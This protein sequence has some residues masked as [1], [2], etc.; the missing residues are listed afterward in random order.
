MFMIAFG[1]P[2]G[3]Y[4]TD[5]VVLKSGVYDDMQLEGFTLYTITEDVEIKANPG[6]NALVIGNTP[7]AIN[8][9]KGLTLTIRGGNA[10]QTTGAGAAIL[11]PNNECGNLYITG[12]GK[13][14][15]YGGNGANGGDGGNGGDGMLDTTW[16]GHFQG[17]RGGT[18]GYGGGGAAAAI[19]G[20]G[21]NGH[22]E[23]TGPIGD[24]KQCEFNTDGYG[25]NGYNSQPG[26]NGSD[27]GKVYVI[28]TVTVEAYGGSAGSYGGWAGQK[29][30]NGKNDAGSGW[31]HDYTASGGA[32]GGGGGS[33]YPADAIGGGAPGAQCG[34]TGASGSVYTTRTSTGYRYMI[35][36]PGEGGKGYK[37]GG[38]NSEKLN[39]QEIGNAG[40]KRS[41]A[42]GR[43]GSNGEL[44]ASFQTK[45][46]NRDAIHF[47][48]YDTHA[49]FH[50]N[51]IFDPTG[52]TSTVLTEMDVVYGIAMNYAPIP[53]RTGMYFQGYYTQKTGGEC[54]F[55]ASGKPTRV[56]SFLGSNT[57]Y[58]HWSE[59]S[60]KNTTTGTNYLENPQDA[61]DEA[62]SGDQI[63]LYSSLTKINIS[64][65]IVL[66]MNNNT[67]DTLI[68]GNIP[69]NIL[70][71]GNG[72]I[73]T[74]GVDSNT[75]T[76]FTG[77]IELTGVNCE[78]LN[79]NGH[80]VSINSGTYTNIINQVASAYSN[81]LGTVTIKGDSTFVRKINPQEGLSYGRIRLMGG[82]YVANPLSDEKMITMPGNFQLVD[83][84]STD[85][86]SSEYT[87]RVAMLS[88]FTNLMRF[89]DKRA[90]DTGFKASSG[91][92]VTCTFSLDKINA[93]LNP[94]FGCTDADPSS[95][96]KGFA[97]FVNGDD[98]SFVFAAGT[99]YESSPAK[100]VEEG[101]TYYATLSEGSLRIDTVAYA[102]NDY[103]H[104]DITMY[105]LRENGKNI[106]L[107]TVEGYTKSES[108]MSVYDFKVMQDSEVL[109]HLMPAYGI[110]EDDGAIKSTMHDDV[111]GKEFFEKN[112]KELESLIGLC[113][114][115]H[116]YR[117]IGKGANAK[118]ICVICG[119]SE[120]PEKFLE[121]TGDIASLNFGTNSKNYKYRV[122]YADLEYPYIQH[123]TTS[124]DLMPLK[125][126]KLF[127]VDV[128][129]G[130][131]LLHH[132]TPSTSCDAFYLKDEVD[133]TFYAV[134]TLA[135]TNYD[136]I[137]SHI[138]KE[139][140]MGDGIIVKKCH[141]CG[142]SNGINMNDA[143]VFNNIQK[144]SKDLKL[145]YRLKINKDI[146]DSECLDQNGD[147]Q[148]WL[149]RQSDKVQLRV[150]Y[151]LN[152]GGVYPKDEYQ[153]GGLLFD[154]DR[155]YTFILD[156][157]GTPDD[158]VMEEHGDTITYTL[159]RY[160]NINGNF[161]GI[162]N[163]SGVN[164]R[165]TCG[166]IT[167]Y[168]FKVEKNGKSYKHFIPSK[169]KDNISLYDICS[170][171]ILT[172]WWYT[173]KN[174]SC[175]LIEP[176]AEHKYLSPDFFEE[177]DD[178][179]AVRT[180]RCMICN[181]GVPD[182]RSFIATSGTSYFNTQYIPTDSTAVFLDYC[183]NDTIPNVSV[184]G[185]VKNDAK[186][187]LE[188]NW[189]MWTGWT[190]LYNDI[191]FFAEQPKNSHH[192][193]KMYKDKIEK[194][195]KF[196]GKEP[197]DIWYRDTPGASYNDNM[198][199]L[200]IGGYNNDGVCEGHSDISIYGCDIYE[201]Q[202]LVRSF[203]PTCYDGQ[204]GLYELLEDK[205]Y[206]MSG[207]G[208]TAYIQSC[209]NHIFCD[210][211]YND[212]DEKWY[213]K[214]RICQEMETIDDEPF[215]TNNG[216]TYFDFG[217]T[218][219]AATSIISN[220]KLNESE[221]TYKRSWTF[222][223]D[224]L[225]T[226]R[227]GEG[228]D[229]FGYP[230]NI[231]I[232][233]INVY[234]DGKLVHKCHPSLWNDS[235]SLYDSVEDKFIPVSNQNLAA[236]YVPTC[237][238]HKYFRIETEDVG[239]KHNIFKHC[240]LCNAKVMLNGI[241]IA[242]ADT[243]R[244]YVFQDGSSKT[245]HI[246]MTSADVTEAYIGTTYPNITNQSII[247][248][249]AVMDDGI[250][251]E[252]FLPARRTTQGDG[253][254]NASR[255]VFI[256]VP[257][258]TVSIVDCDHPYYHDN[259][260]NGEIRSHCCIC[261]EDFDVAGYYKRIKFDANGGSGVMGDQI[262]TSLPEDSITTVRANEFTYGAHYFTGWKQN[263]K[264]SLIAPG[265]K[266]TI[267]S[268][269][270]GDVT[271]YAQWN[272]GFICNGDTLEVNNVN[273]ANIVVKD[274]GVHGFEATGSFTAANISYERELAGN[275]KKWGTL[276][277]PFAISNPDNLQLYSVKGTTE[278]N[279]GSTT[280]T[281]LQLEETA[282]VNAGVPCIYEVK[283]LTKLDKG[284]IL[285]IQ[286]SNVLVRPDAQVQSGSNIN[287]AGKYQYTTFVCDNN[288]AYYAIQGDTFYRVKT[289]MTVPPYHAYLF[290]PVQSN[291]AKEILYLWKWDDATDINSV[292]KNV[293]DDGEKWYTLDGRLIDKPRSGNIYI[294][295]SE[296]G[297]TKKVLVK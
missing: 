249:I 31:S 195:S 228:V 8:I 76:I 297:Y 90:I 127:Y 40:G 262:I 175:C 283:D 225:N 69:Q 206:P 292:Q 178:E 49:I 179:S 174:T 123:V 276:C 106:H 240:K 18:G 270:K 221:G 144:L 131:T 157:S 219:T 9:P 108:D 120:T 129:S 164:G 19:G 112:G 10:S 50:G 213:R 211:I 191:Y 275:G 227:A 289:S 51:I 33:G 102:Q 100:F 153:S 41:D 114:E 186:F 226:F 101:Q 82:Y 247:F 37:W 296:N 185:A 91:T 21:G 36:Y 235:I 121:S 170:G 42:E 253:M 61:F 272:D 4:G 22:G 117:I 124:N 273:T 286:A 258:A 141:A 138:M 189:S 250:L 158:L 17:G 197:S 81:Q 92:S 3:M 74:L 105:E 97:L 65:D 156:L 248:G 55:D 5:V 146:V 29:Y 68:V 199:E 26:G 57:L 115:H 260:V 217:F 109:M 30:G 84:T 256:P 234:E 271:F 162:G 134:N 130:S 218:P 263:N 48:P 167:L 245:M 149:K 232:Y 201:G 78:T 137:A 56:S 35:G 28:G 261:D 291:G 53:Q 27:C 282:T 116:G 267:N 44:Y 290:A 43:Y 148:L 111:T 177:T 147:L 268:T 222:E 231:N 87:C 39:R 180:R 80:F 66:N 188:R 93:G 135:L 7:V 210:I 12:E 58:A 15:V 119:Y 200:Y 280:L 293:S 85:N 122:C 264:G 25:K 239:G 243:L 196:R 192:S 64:K 230:L 107:G 103:Y 118:R 183:Y 34:A 285:R 6:H 151:Y 14:V 71:V 47:E 246:E 60:A 198:C 187:K 63:I 277:L 20:R 257:G 169:Y 46:G 166:D 142:Q 59:T 265:S 77:N 125:D 252:Y 209:E 45:I 168:D 2:I 143:M 287:L 159:S 86:V 73:G 284:N 32:P 223:T 278:K 89:S 182:K 155:D 212:E 244:K 136:A 224:T 269:S 70:Y 79:A 52:P 160:A 62:N 176:C 83:V 266:I 13:L 220:V 75:D 203:S 193:Y 215:I 204:I 238:Y 251:R 181:E 254:Y 173:D 11:V 154:L 172:P 281:I 150:D 140:D 161:L 126:M 241:Q 38:T 255:D 165:W 132:L 294:I 236:A 133:E 128:L 214:C 194:Y 233:G 72:D 23:L 242:S 202:K 208:A 94:I 171:K 99:E 139:K 96:H 95:A 1:A 152:R 229:D 98:K 216:S 184:I 67:I 24:Y 110:P 113:N 88:D 190:S 237:S 279:V 259:Q 274:D 54:I 295:K 145:T 16:P 207:K 104:H 288:N 163:G 205:F